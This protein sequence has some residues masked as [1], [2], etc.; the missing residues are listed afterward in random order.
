MRSVS[1]YGNKEFSNAWDELQFAKDY[2]RRINK[3]QI[4]TSLASPSAVDGF[5][6]K[7]SFA[8]P[9]SRIRYNRITDPILQQSE[10]HLHIFKSTVHK[11]NGAHTD[12]A[13]FTETNIEPRLNHK[14]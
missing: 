3:P 7:T 5:S 11:V 4:S 2:N 8:S 13:F 9:D 1:I 12:T 6:I 10:P 14:K